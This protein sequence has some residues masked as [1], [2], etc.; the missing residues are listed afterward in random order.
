MADFTC[1]MCG[2]C[3]TGEGSVY[4]FPD[5]VFRLADYLKISVQSFV[6]SYTDFILLE[7]LED[8]TSFF[9]YPYLVLKKD[10]NNSCLFLKDKVCSVHIAKPWQCS[11]TPFVAEYFEDK[12]WQKAVA[13]F[14]PGAKDLTEIDIARYRKQ[15]T[16]SGGDQKEDE[17]FHL[18]M[19]HKFSL[20]DILGVS[21]P[22]PSIIPYNNIQE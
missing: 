3:C 15:F 21:L 22:S 12:E 20:E 1:H 11:A 5:D 19:K 10:E 18:L 13:S 4:L 8:E 17:Y 7:V 14:C 16:E 9:Y 2:A 6:D